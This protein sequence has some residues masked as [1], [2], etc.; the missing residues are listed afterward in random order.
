MYVSDRLKNMAES[1]TIKMAQLARELKAQGHEV[2]SLSLGEPDFDTPSHIKEAA[3]RALQEGYTKYTPVPG[4]VELQE[5]IVT[6]FK[7]DNN[8]DFDKNQIVVSN[9]AKQ[10]LANLSLSLLN[11]GDEVIIFA[12][13]WVSYKEIIGLSGAKPV[14]VN[15]TIDNDFKITASQLEAAITAKTRMVLFSSPCNPTG[16]VYSKADFEPLVAVLERH[17]EVLIASDEIYEYINF[18]EGGHC[19]IASFDSI[20]DRCI[21]INGFSKGFSM[22]GWR[23]GYMAAPTWIANACAKMQGQFTSGANSFGQKAAA[24]ALLADMKPTYDMNEAFRKRRDLVLKLLQEIDGFKVNFPEGAFYVFPNISALYGKSVDGQTIQNS[25]DF[26]E[27]ILHKA[28]VAI[29]AG[30]AFGA[31]DCVRIA[32]STSEEQLEEAIKRIKKAVDA[33]S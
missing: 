16:T 28:H 5:A 20:K 24:E 3:N 26:C 9:G 6:K 11:E 18:L 7:R 30:E 27:Y 15:A 12:P 22:T 29:V 17:P 4:L 25:S 32:Y 19:S 14:F 21:V 33:L 23:L 31:D 13:Y 1:A 2:I 10:C 8:L